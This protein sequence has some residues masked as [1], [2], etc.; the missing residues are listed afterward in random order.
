VI[1]LSSNKFDV[2][3]VSV[4]IDPGKRVGAAFLADEVVVRTST[5]TDYDRLVDDIEEFA[6]NHRGSRLNIL[7]GSGAREYRDKL[8]EKLRTR[9]KHRSPK[10][11]LIPE[12]GSSR[13]G[14]KIKVDEEAALIFHRRFKRTF[15]R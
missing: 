4:S 13:M 10:I 6:E 12:H 15:R 1:E 5:Y 8:I 2:Q 14:R 3:E 11:Y 9:L 7:I